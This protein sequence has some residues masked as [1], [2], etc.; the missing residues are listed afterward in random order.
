MAQYV[1]F[2]TWVPPAQISTVWVPG[3]LVLAVTLLIEPRRWPGVLIAAA[4]AV[5][6]LYL[7][8]RMGSVF[9]AGVFGL[10]YCVQTVA[11][12]TMLRVVLR[13]PLALV[14]LPE[15][16]TYLAVAVV[17]GSL[18]GSSLFLGT[19]RAL[20]YGGSFL[21]WRTFALSVML[22][23]LTM[24][25]TVVHLVR[26]ADRIRRAPVRR[27][28]EAGVLALLLVLA[29]G[30]VFS[31]LASRS[32]TWVGLAMTL[33]PLLFWSATRFGSLGA[34]ASLLLV[35][36]IATY[37]TGH[38]LGPF[39]DQSPSD[40]TLSVQL[41]ILGAGVPL[42]GLAIVLSEQRRTKAAL[43]LSYNRLITVREE[44]ATRIARELHDDVG[45]RVALL[46][47]GL[48]RL[49]HATREDPGP[50]RGPDLGQLQEQTSAIARTLRQ[51]SHQLHPAA[52]E[53]AG[54]GAAL[55]LMGEE[56]S[57]A[58]GLDVRFLNHDDDSAV[59][60]EIALCLYRVAQEAVNNVVRHSGAP[61]V[62]MWLRQE[63][64]D[65]VLEVTDDGRGMDVAGAMPGGGLGLRSATERVRAVGGVLTVESTP[66]VGTTIRAVIPLPEADD[67]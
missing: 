12:A 55:Q 28:L 10:L 56:V 25:P 64:T 30:L 17:G 19:T 16:L 65:L 8:M 59:P 21:L 47:I 23:Y 45:Q 1:A 9:E 11:V 38:G 34:S 49:R 29:D 35:S 54:L 5:A 57:R 3:G 39:S 46:S 4:T 37:S 60:S 52:L 31:G 6:L 58:T 26:E 20:G 22:A 36:L 27:W 67:A 63:G 53:H 24:T 44:E 15:F 66:G 14:T 13:R 61:S 18:L 2:L 40:N 32:L 43:E 41:F 7:T 62:T 33:P 51:I 42:L 50:A 48:S